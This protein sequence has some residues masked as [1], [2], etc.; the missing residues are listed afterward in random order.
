MFGR[1]KKVVIE[2]DTKENRIVYIRSRLKTSEETG[3]VCLSAAC[4]L[5]AIR[6]Y[7]QRK[8]RKAK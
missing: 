1:I 3:N 6:P 5:G 7:K 8:K 4:V 2:V